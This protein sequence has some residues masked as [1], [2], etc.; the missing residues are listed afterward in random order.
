M[1][2]TQL[3]SGNGPHGM[4]TSA[5]VRAWAAPGE[6]T[7]PED[8]RPC[9]APPGSRTAAATRRPSAPPLES[10]RREPRDED[11][12]VGRPGVEG[13]GVPVAEHRLHLEPGRGEA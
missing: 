1:V 8:D 10:R 12:L 13:R 2:H 5:A 7:G 9:A 6:A 11:H 4:V 3:P